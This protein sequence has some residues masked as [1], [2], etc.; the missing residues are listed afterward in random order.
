VEILPR[1][2]IELFLCRIS[3]AYRLGGFR[4]S[5]NLSESRALRRVRLALRGSLRDLMN[6]KRRR[7]R[8]NDTKLTDGQ[9]YEPEIK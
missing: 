4:I 6:I 9:L 8:A 2:A 7:R 1:R 3:S 5:F